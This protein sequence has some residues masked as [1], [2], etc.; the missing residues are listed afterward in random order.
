MRQQKG[1]TLIELLVVIAII[2]ILASLAIPQYLKYQVKARVSSYAEPVARGCLMDV[3][4]YCLDK[5]NE[6]FNATTFPNCPSSTSAG[7]ETVTLTLSADTGTCQSDGTPPG[8]YSVTAQIDGINDYKAV[9]T[10]T[11]NAIKCTVQ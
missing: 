8:G 3:V 6:N 5:A 7:G 11:N 10:Y 4:S 2:A 1:F 9:C